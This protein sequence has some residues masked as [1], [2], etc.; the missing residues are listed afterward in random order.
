MSS[1]S[2]RSSRFRHTEPTLRRNWVGCKQVWSARGECSSKEPNLLG[3]LGGDRG[4]GSDRRL[5]RNGRLSCDWGLGISRLSASSNTEP[6]K[7][8]AF[9]NGDVVRDV[10]GRDGL[11]VRSEDRASPVR[12]GR[13]LDNL[14][15]GLAISKDIGPLFY[16]LTMVVV[17]ECGVPVSRIVS[18]LGWHSR[19]RSLRTQFR[20]RVGL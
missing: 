7:D 17:V 13:V 2:R 18:I 19:N 16:C 4:L 20:G 9:L 3:R 8:I 5:S 12:N 6:V 11:E 15:R 1:K 14:L 10:V